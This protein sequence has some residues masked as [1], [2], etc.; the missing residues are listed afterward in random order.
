MPRLKAPS[1]KTRLEF[2]SAVDQIAELE[3]QLRKLT[4]LRDAEIQKIQD[5][6]AASENATEENIKALLSLATAYAE[7]NR[8]DLFAPKK[9]SAETALATFG[10]KFKKA[11]LKLLNRKCTWDGVVFAAKALGLDHLVRT[12]ETP[13]KEAIKSAKLDELTLLQLGV[14]LRGGEVFYVQPKL[15]DAVTLKREAS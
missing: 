5:K 13:D 4:S 15:Y 2:E 7:E 6:Y 10:F 11:A 14:K 12:E 1:L 9:K 3:V 8:G